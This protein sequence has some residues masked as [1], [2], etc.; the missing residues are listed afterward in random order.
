MHKQ[1]ILLIDGTSAFGFAIEYDS[2]RQALRVSRRRE[3]PRR[4]VMLLQTSPNRPDTVVVQ[5]SVLVAVTTSPF[6]VVPV[7]VSMKSSVI[8]VL[9]YESCPLHL[10]VAGMLAPDAL[11]ERPELRRRMVCDSG[12]MFSLRL[13]EGHASGKLD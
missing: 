5:M 12:F 3:T 10:G 1:L 6:A 13:H 7:R 4:P 9:P 8:S 2:E 11:C